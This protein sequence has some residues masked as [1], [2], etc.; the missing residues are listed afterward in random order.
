MARPREFD[1]ATAVRA[2]REAFRRTG[3]AGTSLNDL[4]EATGIAK[5]SLYNAFGTKDQ[6]FERTFDEYC[7]EADAA[8]D[9]V[10]AEKRGLDAVVGYVRAVVDGIIADREHVGCL[11]T[12]GTAELAATSS[13]VVDRAGKTVQRAEGLVAAALHQAQQ[14][15]EIATDRDPR[16]LARLLMA[17][18][19]GIEALDK[20]GYSV[21][22][23][24]AV[25]A[26]AVSLIVG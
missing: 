18:I 9:A 11:M 19:R 23:L 21:E 8:A 3:Y 17:V 5:G 7:D 4:A 1:E 6:L 22:E 14:G 10:F 20:M 13:T 16:E 15:K 12:K 2:A 25:E 24:R 26:T